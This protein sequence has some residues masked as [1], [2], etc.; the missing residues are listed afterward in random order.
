MST[1]DQEP[2]AEPQQPGATPYE[3]YV[4]GGKDT[5][6]R[7]IRNVIGRHRKFVVYV[8]DEDAV[9]WNY[10]QLPE[11]LRPAVVEFQLLNGVARSK[12]GRKQFPK[13][14]ALLGPA[15]YAALLSSEGDNIMQCFDRARSFIYSKCTQ[16]SRLAYV[17]LS[18]AFSGII[19]G[20]TFCMY[21]Y[22]GLGAGL[23]PALLVGIAGGTTGSVVSIIPVS[24]T[25][26]TLP[27]NR[28]V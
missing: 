14:A 4:P 3:N 1:T 5:Y 18:L 16:N 15:L 2:G 23:G 12:L 9:G 26:L 11:R 6:G 17:L 10:D 8:T 19:V 27:T 21:K 22:F 25:H 24:Y 20:L 28:E 7:V 13:I